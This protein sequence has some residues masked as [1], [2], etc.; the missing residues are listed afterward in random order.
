ML[1]AVS[2]ALQSEERAFESLY[3]LNRSPVYAYALS[4]V[5]HQAD[6]EDITQTTFMN[7]YCA[8]HRGVA[9]RDDLQWLLAIARNVCR[10]RFRDAKRKPKEEPLAEWI[11]LVQPDEP[12]FAVKDVVRELASLDPRQRE[13]LVLR[14]FEGRSYAEISAQLGVSEAAVQT[15]LVRARRSLRDELELGI[16]CAHARR[17]ALRNMNGVA[18][19]EERRALKRHLRRCPDC[20]TFVGQRPRTPMG[21][22]IW[23]VTMPYRKLWSIIVGTSAIPSA[24]TTAGGAG[25]VAVKLIAAAAIGTATIGVTANELGT[26]TPEKAGPARA[27]HTLAPTARHIA[28]AAHPVFLPHVATYTTPATAGSTAARTTGDTEETPETAP[29][30]SPSPAV[31]PSVPSTVAS[32]TPP[33]PAPIAT[34]QPAVAQAAAAATQEAA[35][36]TTDAPSATPAESAPAPTAP[37]TPAD[38]TAATTAD[39]ST[40]PSAPVTAPTDTSAGTPDVMPP[41][42]PG[43]SSGNHYGVGQGGTPPGQAAKTDG[44]NGKP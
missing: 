25:A 33:A 19:L 13:I 6:A 10:D 36:A 12:E 39:P 22:F 11:R 23:L 14:E 30:T 29:T 2:T 26:P 15:L 43:Q 20:A 7:A 1:G 31:P 16:T 32:S 27:T 35:P 18:V 28:P 40:A 34:D 5:H 37:G 21:Q 3:R 44:T 24:T 42:G 41:S 9:P 4:R 17:L 8:L 38:A